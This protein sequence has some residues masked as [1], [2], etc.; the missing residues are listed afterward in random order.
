MSERTDDTTHEDYRWTD[1]EREVH[2]NNQSMS[3][4]VIS[5]D[6]QLR[7]DSE[8]T[9][10]SRIT[11]PILPVGE[12]VDAN[13]EMA[14]QMDPLSFYRH[15]KTGGKWDYKQTGKPLDPNPCEGPGN[16]NYGATAKAA[17][18]SDDITKMAAGAYQIYS[19]TSKP[20]WGGPEKHLLPITAAKNFMTPLKGLME[21]GINKYKGVFTHPSHGD[22]PND[23]YHIEQG[24]KY[25]DQYERDKK[26]FYN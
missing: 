25:Y 5:S 6:S 21:Y 20:E 19:G 1:H 15:V 9:T 11:K 22:D 3:E 10:Q 16:I 23:Q 4:N 2:Y 26:E 12:D 7:R 18:F 8:K 14:K 13:I 17:G 24:I